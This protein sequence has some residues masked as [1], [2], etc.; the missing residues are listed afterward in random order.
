MKGRPFGVASSF[1]QEERP[2]TKHKYVGLDVHQATTS[3]AVLD[4]NG[5]LLS[6]ST[7]QTSAQEIRDFISGLS[8][9]IHLTFEEG[10][11]AAWLY[12]LIKPL[13]AELIVCDP[14]RERLF[15]TCLVRGRVF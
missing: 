5:K 12:D 14:R 1:H 2:M 15:A 8:G 7:V 9:T 10:T 6:Q 4:S 13:V 11:Q 3:I